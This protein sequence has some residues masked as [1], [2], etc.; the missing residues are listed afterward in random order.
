MLVK[1]VDAA[2]HQIALT[3]GT[4]ISMEGLKLLG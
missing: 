1:Q 4:S 2:P 3:V